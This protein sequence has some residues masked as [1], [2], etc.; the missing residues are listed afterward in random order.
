ML[1]PAIQALVPHAALAWAVRGLQPRR[2]VRDPPVPDMT[3]SRHPRAAIAAAAAALLL[4]ACGGG[5][6]TS[7]PT[8]QAHKG[9]D[10]TGSCT[11]G[12]GTP[13][14]GTNPL[15]T[16]APA[17]DV[18]YRESFGPGPQGVRPK[19]GKGDLRSTFIGTTLGGFWVEWPGSKNTGWIT[20]AGE[21][22]WKFTASVS[23][24]DP[25]GNPYEMA[26]PLEVGG[27]RGVVWSDVTDGATG[28]HPAALLPVS[29]PATGWS[30]SMEGVPAAG[31]HLALGLTDSGTTLNNLTTVGK[32]ALLLRLDATATQLVWELWLGGATRTLLAS[33]RTDDQYHNQ[34]QLTY[35]PPTQQLWARVNGATVGPFT[36]NLG[37]PRYAGFEGTG[38]ADD[39]VIHRLP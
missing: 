18:L 7:G 3:P 38:V 6:D 26:S 1:L 28:G 27:M 21:A 14:A 25:V 17:P 19:G 34:L 2:W 29:L 16:S 24:N 37:A 13:V 15:P 39:F 30:V 33:G 4:S 10:C 31:G 23:G 11:G 20:P 35:S 8:V 36:A 12:G 32:V 22:T 5:D 9:G